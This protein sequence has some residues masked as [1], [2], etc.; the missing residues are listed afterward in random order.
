MRRWHGT[1]DELDDVDLIYE[2]RRPRVEGRFGLHLQPEEQIGPIRWLLHEPLRRQTQEVAPLA[3]PLAGKS[4]HGILGVSVE[5]PRHSPPQDGK[6]YA[7]V[8]GQPPEHHP[9]ILRG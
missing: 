4:P 2:E 3:E 9:E 5:S 8:L 7:E 6:Q 1:R